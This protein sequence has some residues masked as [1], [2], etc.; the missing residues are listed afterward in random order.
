MSD[1]QNRIDTGPMT[2]E[3]HRRSLI[4]LTP[5]EVVRV[6]GLNDYE[7][8]PAGADPSP[9]RIVLQKNVAGGGIND[10]YQIGETVRVGL[11]AQGTTV[12]VRVGAAQDV[13]V[14]DLLEMGVAGVLTE[15]ATNPIFSAEETVNVITGAGETALVLARL[16][17]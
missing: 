10:A 13:V 5:G 1:A 17:A 12:N 6:N 16:T 2:I 9:I 14:P 15:G 8:R 3:Y 11:P 7:H 4:V